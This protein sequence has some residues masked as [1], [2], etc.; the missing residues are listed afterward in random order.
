MLGQKT[1]AQNPVFHIP[2]AMVL[3]ILIDIRSYRQAYHEP[4]CLN[5]C[6]GRSSMLQRQNCNLSHGE[7]KQIDHFGLSV[8]ESAA[9]LSHQRRPAYVME[10]DPQMVPHVNY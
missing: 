2:L 9:A 3:F 4:S 7:R 8:P 6:A 5:G 10:L 1:S